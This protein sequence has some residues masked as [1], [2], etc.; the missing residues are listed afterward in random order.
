MNWVKDGVEYVPNDNVKGIIYI[1]EYNGLKYIGKKTI[2]N[3]KKKQTNWKSYYGS[4]KSWLEH[5]DGNEDKVTREVLYECA[6]LVE[7][8]YYED[9]ELYSRHVVF[10][11]NY[12]N[13]NVAMKTNVKNSKNFINKPFSK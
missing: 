4:S 6:N 8:G 10:D 3:S 2:I 12:A 1:M 11:D 7:M 13:R 9:Y 5:I